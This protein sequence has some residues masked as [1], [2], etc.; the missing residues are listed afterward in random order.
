MS[1]LFWDGERRVPSAGEG[2]HQGW[3]PRDDVEIDLFLH[4]KRSYGRVSVERV[5]AGPGFSAIYRFLVETGRGTETR[6]MTRRMS[7]ED[8]NAAISDAGVRGEDETAE[9]AVDLFVSAYG[10]AAGDLALVSRAL[11]GVWI[12]GGIAPKILPKLRSGDFL[13]SFRTKG[14]LSGVVERIPVRVIL[15]PRTALIGAAARA[16]GAPR[17]GRRPQKR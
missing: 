7:E 3:A 1:I 14:R 12:G 16:A 6:E 17:S 10:A 4:L 5:V 11:G 15:E 2:G 9:R 8:P 13:R